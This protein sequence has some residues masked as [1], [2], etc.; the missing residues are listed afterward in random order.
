VSAELSHGEARSL[1]PALV[2]RELGEPDEVRLRAHLEICDDCRTGWT[3]Y[4]RAVEKVRSLERVRAP[5][6][7]ASQVLLRSRR[8]RGLRAIAR[9]EADYRL[10]T[11][12]IIPVLIAA[13]VA[14]VIFLAL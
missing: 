8:R 1:F 13:L 6:T 3:R 4:E 14:L 7:F 11:E 2:D 9:A 10:P 5:K 12:I